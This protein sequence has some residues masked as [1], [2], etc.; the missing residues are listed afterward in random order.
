MQIILDCKWPC[1]RISKMIRIFFHFQILIKYDVYSY[2]RAGSR[3][4][5]KFWK[6]YQPP[7]IRK[8][9]RLSRIKTTIKTK[10]VSARKRNNVLAR[11]L[12]DLEIVNNE[13][14]TI[15]WIHCNPLP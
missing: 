3:A 15:S 14:N 11:I 5:F 6:K 12:N 9:D 2:V 10:V 8:I 1:S 7:I 4:N 13:K